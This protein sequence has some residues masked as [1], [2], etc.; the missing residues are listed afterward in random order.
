MLQRRNANRGGSWRWLLISAGVL[1][2]C[3]LGCAEKP[4][5]DQKLTVKTVEVREQTPPPTLFE[6]NRRLPPRHR[7]LKAEGKPGEKLVV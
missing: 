7:V 1:A 2:L 6:V 3:A 4:R 5:F